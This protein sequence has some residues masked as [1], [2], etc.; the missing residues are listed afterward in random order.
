MKGTAMNKKTSMIAAA[1]IA[2]TV[3]VAFSSA[4]QAHNQAYLLLPDGRCVV[5]GAGNFVL[6]PDGSYIIDL[7][8]STPT[9]QEFGTSHAAVEGNSRV[10]KGTCP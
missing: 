2:S 8:P 5:V 7:D 10:Q 3:G 1:A 4:A 6:R 9:H